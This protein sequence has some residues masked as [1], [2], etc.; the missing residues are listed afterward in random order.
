MPSTNFVNIEVIEEL[1]KINGKSEETMF[2]EHDFYLACLRL[3][4]TIEDMRYLS[5]VDILKMFLCLNKSDR[6]KTEDIK[7]ATQNDIDRL[8]S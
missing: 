1:N 2:P 8:L 7:Y 3:G 5:Y 6:K 4:L